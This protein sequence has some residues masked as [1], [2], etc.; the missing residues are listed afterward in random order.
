MSFSNTLLVLSLSC[1]N[2]SGSAFSSEKTTGYNLNKPDHTLILPDTLREISGLT[3]INTSFIACIQDENG[4]LFIFDIINN[5]IKK[6]YNFH[7]DGDYEGITRVG[8]TIYILRSDGKLFEISDYDSEKFTLQ[9][10]ITGIPASNNEGLCY[11]ADNNRLLLA[12]KSKLGKGPEFKNQRVIY[13]FDLKTK[14]LSVQPVYNF[15]VTTI[16]QFAL[17]NELSLPVRAKKYG[18]EPVIK[19]FT[20]AIGIHPLTKKLYLLSASDHMLFIFD[21]NGK[22]EHIELLNPEELFNKAEGITFFSNGDM[23]IT[24]EGQDKKPTLLRFNYMNK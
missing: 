11:D 6:Q 4:I 12:C 14:K 16:K 22:L 2:I 20:S 19:F 7:I 10:Y 3:E 18:S 9:S 24:N 1:L 15:D 5:R 23:L 21:R 8:K 17:E 13:G